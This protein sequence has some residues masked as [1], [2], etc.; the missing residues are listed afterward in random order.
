MKSF[1]EN[2]NTIYYDITPPFFVTGF[3]CIIIAYA[4]SLGFKAVSRANILIMP[5]AMISILLILLL[6]FDNLVFQRIFPIL[7]HGIKTTFLDGLG[8]LFAFGNISIIYFLPSFLT[9]PK[10][11]KK[12]SVYGVIWSSFCLF[13]SI[14]SILFLFSY[15]G[16]TNGIMPLYLASREIELGRFFQRID[17]LFILLWTISIVCFLTILVLLAT[18]ILKNLTSIKNKPVIS[19]GF[20]ILL[21]LLCLIPKNIYN[22][23]FLEN[24]IYKYFVILFVFISNIFILLLAN[25]KLLKK[26]DFNAQKI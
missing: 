22:I 20:S 2:L 4:C 15:I 17:A 8:N 3:I 24:A 5:I 13:L 9:D 23:F 21:F 19:I 18:K 12:V 1:S 11:L 26:E 25:L 10:E 6:N 16:P 14:S 7:G